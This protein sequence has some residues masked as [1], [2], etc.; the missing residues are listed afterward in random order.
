MF[1]W[2]TQANNTKRSFAVDCRVDRVLL[3]YGLFWADVSRRPQ[4]AAGE[5]TVFIDLRDA[6]ICNYSVAGTINTIEAV[7]P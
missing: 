3:A 1:P 7:L 2:E 4:H 6:E 5:I